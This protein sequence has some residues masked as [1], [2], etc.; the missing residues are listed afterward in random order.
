VTG[1]EDSVA[2]PQSVR[3]M[4]ERMQAS[5]GVRTVVLSRCGHWTPIERPDDCMRALRDFMSTQR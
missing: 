2:P 1:D 3:A 5:R 4:G